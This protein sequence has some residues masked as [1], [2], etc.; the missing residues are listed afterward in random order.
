MHCF[1]L[2]NKFYY[3]SLTDLKVSRLLDAQKEEPKPEPLDNLFS[4]DAHEIASDLFSIF[5]S[6]QALITS[7]LSSDTTFGSEEHLAEVSEAHEKF[8]AATEPLVNVRKMEQW[9]RPLHPFQTG[10]VTSR[11][12][13]ARADVENLNNTFVRFKASIK[14]DQSLKPALRECHKSL[15]SHLYYVYGGIEVAFPEYLAS[16]IDNTSLSI[17]NC[18]ER[19]LQNDIAQFEASYRVC[20]T[21]SIKLARISNTKG[22]QTSNV[23]VQRELGDCAFTCLRASSVLTNLGR[24]YM[25]DHSEGAVQNMAQIAKALVGQYQKIGELSKIEETQTDALFTPETI[26]S[27]HAGY[28]AA[29]K[30]LQDSVAQYQDSGEYDATVITIC[31]KLMGEVPVFKSTL[32]EPNTRAFSRAVANISRFIQLLVIHVSSLLQP[33]TDAP[34]YHMCLNGMFAALHYCIQLN[35]S[36]ACKSL[37][38]PIIPPELSTLCSIRLMFGSLAVVLINALPALING[39]S[40]IGDDNFESLDMITASVSV[41]NASVMDV[42]HYGRPLIIRDEPKLIMVGGQEEEPKKETVNTILDQLDAELGVE[43]IPA[44]VKPR[45]EPEEMPQPQPQQATPKDTP[46]SN[47][48]NPLG[49]LPT[50]PPVSPRSEKIRPSLSEYSRGGLGSEPVK[51]NTVSAN[52][53]GAAPSANPL[54]AAPSTANPLG[55]PP[56]AVDTKPAVA[57]P[58]K[59][60][61]T[62]A[63][64]AAPVG[65]AGGPP[66]APTPWTTIPA[67][68]I[69]ENNLP[70]GYP[71]FPIKVGAFDKN[72]SQDDY[73]KWM[74]DRYNREA[75][76]NALIVYKRKLKAAQQSVGIN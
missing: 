36:S 15:L 17:Q 45:K 71:D 24:G 4:L 48:A 13:N 39:N 9:V 5:C 20:I 63:A 57:E 23:D 34:V 76:E 60:A 28:D 11:A 25:V 74:V 42:L 6:Y 50:L 64:S 3:E 70:P 12:S 18:M 44:P 53:L 67:D 14:T 61:N 43:H 68:T 27:F 49:A 59:T 31:E 40:A 73:K 65:A 2:A 26:A 66:G 16:Q 54:G 58:S 41:P 22:F 52:P 69:D 46:R 21:E 47:N 37:Y 33:D 7:F 19:A 29:C 72:G 10:M 38:H 1:L 56:K 55:A 51:T 35:V 62:G 75:A 8:L 30:L 32:T